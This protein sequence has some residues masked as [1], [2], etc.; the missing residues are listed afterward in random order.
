[1]N[2]DSTGG[3]AVPPTILSESE[4]DIISKLRSDEEF[5]SRVNF[6]S[7]SVNNNAVSLAAASGASSTALG[8]PTIITPGLTPAHGI[9]HMPNYTEA[10]STAA[11]GVSTLLSFPSSNYSDRTDTDSNSREMEE[12]IAR[13]KKLDARYNAE[14]RNKRKA[15]AQARKNQTEGDT[16]ANNSNNITASK[17]HLRLNKRNTMKEK[18]IEYAGLED[19]SSPEEDDSNGNEALAPAKK[20][21][22]KDTN[23]YFDRTNHGTHDNSKIY[24]GKG[25]YFMI[26]EKGDSSVILG[27]GYS[28]KNFYD[29]DSA[30]ITK[31]IRD[32]HS[33]RSGLPPGDVTTMTNILPVARKDICCKDVEVFILFYLRK[34]LPPEEVRFSTEFFVFPSRDEAQECLSHIEKILQ[35]LHD[36]KDIVASNCYLNPMGEKICLSLQGV[37]EEG[38]VIHWQNHEDYTDW[39][40]I[41]HNISVM[42][43]AER[44]AKRCIVNSGD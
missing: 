5:A 24:T 27:M 22:K 26:F 37:D 36:V 28:D 4:F 7:T 18:E 35:Q 42:L 9:T 44:Q 17:R 8:G 2:Q 15:R 11:R 38:D 13:K 25:L 10:P 19:V 29:H 34:Y 43:S 39:V 23:S 16:A 33:Y 20:K 14:R 32:T 21:S 41:R 6:L 31:R 1:M 3:T 40:R 30:G 12:E